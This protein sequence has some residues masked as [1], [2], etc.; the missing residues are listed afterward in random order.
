MIVT[1]MKTPFR[2][3]EPR[4]VNDR[5]YKSFF[6]EGFRESLLENVKGNLLENSD[7]SFNNFINT[8]NNVLDTQLPQKRYMFEV[9]NRLL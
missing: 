1:V 7:E 3:I 6:N 8:F 5:N 2:K 9:I 4:V